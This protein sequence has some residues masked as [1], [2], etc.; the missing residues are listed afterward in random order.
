MMLRLLMPRLSFSRGEFYLKG[1]LGEKRA[2]DDDRR[3]WIE[4]QRR[5]SCL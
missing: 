2:D 3:A 1:F 5:I 4:W